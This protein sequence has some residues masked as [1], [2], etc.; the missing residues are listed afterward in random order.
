M[1]FEAS[2]EALGGYE[3]ERFSYTPALGIHRSGMTPIGEVLVTES[4][5]RSA[6]ERSVSAGEALREIETLLGSP[7]DEELE[8]YRFAG[9]SSHEVRWVHEVG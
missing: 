4:R 6:I 1:R 2:Q 9:A 5:I 8:P 7:W 3:G